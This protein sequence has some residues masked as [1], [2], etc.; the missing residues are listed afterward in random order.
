MNYIPK[1]RKKLRHYEYYNIQGLLDALYKRSQ[2]GSNFKNLY[3]LIISRENILVAY[4]NIKRNKGSKT[5]GVIKEN[6]DDL[7]KLSDEEI[8]DIVRENLADYKPQ[9]VRRKEIRKEN[10]K[11]R[12]LGIPTIRD[13]LIQQCILQILEPICEA[14]F[15]KHSYGFRPNRNTSHA[16]ARANFLI[17][18]NQMN[19]CVDIDIKG[20]FDNVNHGKLL[21]QM[22]TLGI[23]DKRVLSIISKIL[24]SEIK[25]EGIP[26]KGTPQGG[27]IS[28]LLSNIVLNELDWWLSDQWLT[29]ETKKN[30]S[31]DRTKARSLRKTSLK[32]IYHVRYADDFK[33]FCKDFKT[34]QRIYIATVNWLK[35]RLGLEISETKSKIVNLRN[36]YSE[37]LGFKIKA[38]NRGDKYVCISH[39]NDKS[40]KKIEKRLRDQFKRVNKY[41]NS[42]E[43]KKL[44]AMILGMHNY[45]KMATRVSDDFNEIYYNM[46]RFITNITENLRSKSGFKSK[47][48]TKIYGKYNYKE[49]NLLGYT[50]YPIPGVK[51]FTPTCFNQNINSYTEEG[52]KLIHDKLKGIDYTLLVYLMENPVIN[53]S[54]EFNDNRVSLYVGQNGKC[55][56]SGV[57]LQIGDME[58]HHKKPISDGGTDDYKNLI[59]LK[60][61]IHRLIHMEDEV[62][63][64]LYMDKLK[65]KKEQIEKINKLRDIIG[66]TNL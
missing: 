55:G 47:A 31:Y 33:I 53:R 3:E 37:F 29:F 19:Y 63:I 56:I 34:A 8:I 39:V 50:L 11:M 15:H 52:R 9:P 60:T 46:Y 62:K 51:M 2:Q 7:S 45:Y 32:E 65:L 58:V 43:V 25:G 22:W 1:K 13:R 48:Y 49:I 21:K 57:Q 30:Y 18:C 44:N 17:N 59:F 24:K 40:K 54:V 12:P 41:R 6:I 36:N 20:F 66:K 23:R 4:R 42:N 16:I 10:G 14:K 35:E 5:Y 61:E 64:K 27:I 28:P 26:N 38:I